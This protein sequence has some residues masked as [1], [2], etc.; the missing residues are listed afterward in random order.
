MMNLEI[1]RAA[2]LLASPAISA[3]NLAMKFGVGNTI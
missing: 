3:K 2:A 1:F